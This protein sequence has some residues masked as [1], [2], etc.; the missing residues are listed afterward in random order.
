MTKCNVNANVEEAERRILKLE[1]ENRL[2]RQERGLPPAP[3]EAPL[4]PQA[5]APTQ[6]E[7]DA[8]H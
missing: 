7:A 2:L 1:L 6:D 5:D 3:S 8:K 4:V